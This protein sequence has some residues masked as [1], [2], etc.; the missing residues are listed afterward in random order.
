MAQNKNDKSDL[1]KNA[2]EASIDFEALMDSTDFDSWLDSDTN[3]GLKKRGQEIA[4]FR[5]FKNNKRKLEQICKNM[6]KKGDKEFCNTKDK[7]LSDKH[8]IYPLFDAKL[9]RLNA[10]ISSE[11]KYYKES[12]LILSIALNN[13]QESDIDTKYWEILFYNDLSICYAGLENSSIS[14]GYAEEAREIIEGEKN[15][16]DF[17]KKFKSNTKVDFKKDEFVSSRLYDLYTVAVFNQA[18]AEKR[19]HMADEAEKNFKK[20]INYTYRQVRG[21]NC[22]LNFNFYSAIGNLSDLYIDQ[23]R[24]KEAI[25]LLNIAIKSIDESDIRYWN[26]YLYI[27]TALIDQCEYDS[28]K[29][30]L[31]NKFIEKKESGLT[32]SKKH[33][34][35]SPGFKGMN[36]YAR[37]Q[38]EMVKNTLKAGVCYKKSELKEAKN[39]INENKNIII[40]ERKQKG[41]ETKAYKHL[42]D[43]YE[44][45]ENDKKRNENLT[46][47]LSMGEVDTI[48][49]FVRR[50]KMERWIDDC[51]DLNALESFSKII[52]NYINCNYINGG[53][54]KK[55]MLSLLEEIKEKIIRECEDKGQLS[56]AERE[57]RKIN[58][59]LEEADEVKKVKYEKD[60]FNE[61]SSDK[62][63]SLTSYDIRKRLDRNEKEFDSVLF[64]R[65]EMS[66]DNLVEVIV[67]R[68][69]NSFS[70][71][72]FAGNTGS[73]GGG[74][75]LR[76]NNK[77]SENDKKI[78][79]NIVIDPGY[80]FLQNFR[81]E[82][83]RID[84]I[85]T[86]IITHSHLDHC[87]EL[88]PIMDLIY[89]INKRYEK[90]K[91]EQ[92]RNKK[93]VSLCLSQGAYNK[94]STYTIDPDWQKQ[95]KDV[96]ILENLPDKKWKLDDYGLTISAI[97]TLHMDLGGVKGIGL[98][99]EINGNGGGKKAEFKNLCLGFTSD[100]PWDEKIKQA[101]KKCDLLCI[102]LGSIKYE[103]IGYTDDRYKEGKEREIPEKEKQKKFEEISAKSNHLLFFGTKDI[104]ASCA[105][106]KNDLVIV[107][108]FGEELKYGLRTE[109]CKKLSAESGTC[110]PCDIGLYIAIE[111]NGIKKVRC[112]FCEEF[113]KPEEIRTFSYGREDAIHYICNTCD[114]TLSE[115]QK[116]AIVEHRS[117]RH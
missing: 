70:P 13:L 43:I 52:C 62:E 61:S 106:K 3:E 22:L 65:T 108:E 9:K 94:F 29:K 93:R 12:L 87:A 18:Q 80:N 27:I 49:E 102:H 25:E 33:K 57:V 75:F 2:I 100:T 6:M 48:E 36:H 78:S 95:L 26:A 117:T 51:D 17:E 73:L 72:L 67:L 53:E 44:I 71:G 116:H 111:K 28:A 92:K 83:F 98:K 20:I 1:I 112:G 5:K 91:N 99:I 35:T 113:V 21:E 74:Y 110:F 107:G 50:E 59:V 90:Y 40:N 104:I 46:K 11:E 82:K 76:I 32:L 55:S 7:S 101:F 97:P 103:E 109:L 47:F 89:Q 69:W 84:D 56:R 66:N 96:I 19:S 39:F 16:K 64:N 42:S 114:K 58:E 15:Y 45:L 86:I 77:L 14:R 85:D 54:E 81:S 79:H 30:L 105:N 34:V 23:G 88:L 68:R 24:G 41:A 37:C 60:F 4:P 8:F 10:R 31:L 63:K 38:I 115:L